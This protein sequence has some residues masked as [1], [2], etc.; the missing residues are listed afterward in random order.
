MVNE[1]DIPAQRAPLEPTDIRE[2]AVWGY[3]IEVGDLT[4]MDVANIM[5]KMRQR[6]RNGTKF[7]GELTEKHAKVKA[8]HHTA[9][10]VAFAAATGPMEERKHKAIEATADLLAEVEDLAAQ[11]RH[12]VMRREDLKD[13]LTMWQA[14]NKNVMQAWLV[15]GD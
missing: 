6:V 9:V 12:A 2:R 1:S 4:P 11:V 5:V 15:T 10:S 8:R 7:C 3:D 14:I 13:E